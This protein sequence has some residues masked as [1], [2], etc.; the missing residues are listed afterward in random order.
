MPEIP[1]LEAYL[2]ALHTLEK[3]ERGKPEPWQPVVEVETATL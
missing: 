2:Y 1:D 3:L